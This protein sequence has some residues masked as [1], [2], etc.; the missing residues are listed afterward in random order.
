VDPLVLGQLFLSEDLPE[1]L[2][3]ILRPPEPIHLDQ[4]DPDS[5]NGAA[6]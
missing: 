1:D 2:R 6:G 3:E 5:R 4:I